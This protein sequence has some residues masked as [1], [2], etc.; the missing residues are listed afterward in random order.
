LKSLFVNR[1][2]FTGLPDL[3]GSDTAKALEKAHIQS[4]LPAW[5]T[6][7]A[8]QGRLPDGLKILNDVLKDDFNA[9]VEAE[10]TDENG[11]KPK[12]KQLGADFK[13]WFFTLYSQPQDGAED[14]WAP[15]YLEYQFA[16]S[17]PEDAF[18]RGRTMLT[19][20]QYH[21]GHL[22]WYSFDAAPNERLPE[23]PGDESRFKKE[24]PIAFIPTQIEFNGMPNVRWWAFEDRRTD[25]GRLRAGTTDIAQLM[26]AE[27]GLIYGTDWSVLPYNLEA[28]SLCAI[29]GIVV[30]DVFGLRTFI[31]PALDEGE[32]TQ[33]WNLYKLTLAGT[34]LEVD[35]RLFL[36]PAIGKMQE[37]KPI[38]KVLLARD[39]MANMVWGVE[40]IIPGIFGTGVNGFEA[41]TALSNYFLQNN[42]RPEIAT[43]PNEAK[44]Q[45]RLGTS[46]PENWIPFIASRKP[47][48]K[49]EIRLQRASMPRLTDGFPDS[50]V[51]PRGQILRTGLDESTPKSYFIHEEEVS[52]AGCLVTRSYQ[53]TRWFDG[54]V[55]TW[56]GR[57]KQTGKGEGA[58]G[59]QF[60]QVVPQ[61]D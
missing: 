27:F 19:A 18:D 54:R 6:L 29:R 48:S 25:F 41:A 42:T 16:V 3:S 35:H 22:D 8:L 33:H 34:A 23:G 2:P 21:Q 45:F 5:Q 51:E 53:R 46:V 12:V 50:R 55:F 56:L 17:A 4:E 20:E 58:S 11:L 52:R 14:A 10:I 9:W 59:L 28:G 30:T 61:T 1:Y 57:R 40:Q 38:E 36:P 26:L 39:E 7:Q 44:I 24:D 60:D 43:Q 47:G 15:S 32:A 49:R 13:T 37:G 31:R